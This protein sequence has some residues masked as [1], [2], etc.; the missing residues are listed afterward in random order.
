MTEER[1]KFSIVVPTYN[2]RD[3]AVRCVQALAA[4]ERPWPCELIVVIDGSRD[5]TREA[6]SALT[7]PL[8]VRIVAQDNTG[9]AGARN[10]GA[11][12]ATG[13]YLLFLD[14]DMI[15]DP[16]ILVEHA[17]ILDGADADA[18]VGHIPMHPDSPRTVL[19][20]GLE[21][22]ADERRTRLRRTGGELMLDDLITGQLAVRASVFRE[23]GGFDEDF[24]AGGSFGGED[25]DF[26]YRLL[27]D[28]A[29]VRFAPDAISYQF[30]VVTPTSYLRQWKQAGRAD[31][32]LSRKHP[33]LGDLLREQHRGRTT[34]GR[35]ARAAARAASRL[36]TRVTDVARQRVLARAEAGHT[37][38]FTVAAF[39][40][41][42]DSYYWSGA[43]RGGGL[44]PG[45]RPGLRI[46]AYHAIEAIDDPRI[47]PYAVEPDC[48]E[49]QLDAL[50]RAGF[51]FVGADELLAALD[52]Q[53]PKIPSLVLTFDDAY[54]S[55]AEHVAPA[56]RRL[57]IPAVVFVVTGEIGGTNS[58]DAAAGATPLSLL[59]AP[60]LLA[61]HEDGWE[62]AAHSHSHAHLPRL[63]D[64]ALDAELV[65]S[66]DELTAL[67]LP[68]PRLFAYPY[69]EHDQRVR[70][71]VL[72]AGYAAAVALRGHR[73]AP[74]AT[75]RYALPRIEVVRSHE[76]E[77]LVDLVLDPPASLLL[78]AEREARGLARVA[79][80]AAAR[81]GGADHGES[82]A[83]RLAG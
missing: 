36:P 4:A 46:L 64:A 23:L 56:L 50:S 80:R 17:G 9:A 32:L 37:D 14:D 22:W 73:S 62:I 1:Y 24:T 82:R 20:K 29:R 34:W 52:G 55:L 40:A 77:E 69:G 61:L 72:A 51:A 38:E 53:Q 83:D 79:I 35:I 19:S 3:L 75:D 68:A 59:D 11:A 76:P 39:A 44:R 7:L 63:D 26:L 30:Y 13:E 25:T 12:L 66:R 5:G 57:G 8:P 31:A 10:H 78:A 65:A 16:E 33:G 42:R 58:W 41:M 81:R 47:G 2:R 70:R 54:T 49:R 28:G 15:A 43:Q 74:A 6:L 48:F 60:A 45:A 21:R 18:T 27:D 71:R 67:G